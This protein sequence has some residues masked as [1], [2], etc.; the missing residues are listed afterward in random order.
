MPLLAYCMMEADAA[1]Q[2][3]TTAHHDALEAWWGV[4][5]DDFARLRDCKKMPEVRQELLE[6]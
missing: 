2:K 1:V 5:R 3:T 6:W 4:A